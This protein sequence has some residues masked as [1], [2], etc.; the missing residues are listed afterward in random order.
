MTDWSHNSQGQTNSQSQSQMYGMN[1]ISGM[2]QQ[3]SSQSQ[4]QVMTGHMSM[5]PMDIQAPHHPGVMN[6]DSMHMVLVA[7]QLSS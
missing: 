4:H 6:S 1:N 7:L 2:S 3:Q 5:N